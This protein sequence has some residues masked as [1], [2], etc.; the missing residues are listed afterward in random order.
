MLKD[1]PHLYSV[2]GD[3]LFKMER[4]TEAKAAFERAAELTN[5]ERELGVLHRRIADCRS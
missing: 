3:L 5:N 2:R 1:Y 4:M